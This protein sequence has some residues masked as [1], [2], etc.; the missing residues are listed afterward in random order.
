MRP[1]PCPAPL[2]RRF[3]AG[4]AVLGL[5]AL[6]ACDE[7]AAQAGDPAERPARPV[8]V[9]AATLAVHADDVRGSGLV[10]Y[11]REVALSFK[12]GG[13]V[14]DFAVDVGDR[15]QADQPLVELDAAEIDAQWREAVAN[16]EKAQRDVARLA[17][18]VDNGYASKARL[19]DARTAL[20]LAIAARDSVAF[21]RDLAEIRAPADGVVLSRLVETGQIVPAGQAILTLGDRESGQVVKVGIAD[22]EVVKIA[23][24]DVAEVRLPG[25]DAP[26]SATVSRISPKGDV[27]TGAFMVELSLDD[28]AIESLSGLVADVAIRPKRAGQGNMVM[29]PASAILE[30]FGS[31]GSVFVVNPKTATVERRHVSFGPLTGEN[32]IVRDGLAPGEQVVSAGAGYLREGDPVRVTDQMALRGETSPPSQ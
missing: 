11:K 1:F 6:G 27:R 28:T 5:L 17:P 26:V 32:V 20:K 2:A 9:A 24:G 25:R 13:V 8:A 18:L 19:D 16:V 3:L 10:A 23:L 4:A 29:I 7:S 21:N 12:I 31:E 22:R 30:G 14:R 15:V